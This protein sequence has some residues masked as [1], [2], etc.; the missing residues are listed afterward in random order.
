MSRQ[1]LM[2]L[3]DEYQALKIWVKLDGYDPDLNRELK[4][5]L[6]GPAIW[7]GEHKF[8]VFPAHW[9]TCVK[10]REVANRFDANIKISPSLNE[11]AMQEKG[12]QA[13]IPDVQSMQLV[14]LP[15]VRQ[16]YPGIWDAIT[17]RPYQ[18]VCAAFAA[19]NRSC[20]IADQPGLGK[21][22]QTIAAIVEA[23]ICGPIL[24]VAPKAAVQL[25][26]PQ[27][28]KRWLPTDNVITLDSKLSPSG[29]VEAVKAALATVEHGGK[30]C[31]LITSPNYVRI[32]AKVDE[33]GNY[34]KVNGE[35]VIHA[36]RETVLELFGVEWSAIVVD[37]SHQTL[38]GATGNKKKQSAQRLG[39]GALN[40]R[41]DGLRIAL[42][43]TPFRGKEY[44]LWG[45]LNWLRPD[46]Y[47]SYW[48]WI[49]RHFN[50]WHDGYGQQIGKMI[51]AE[52][53]YDE[54]RNV[55]IRRT[56]E[57]VASD[58]PAKLYGGWPLIPGGPV[59]VWLDMEPKQ[60]AA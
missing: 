2:G 18:T 20:S 53:M 52:A 38:A 12:R 30:R 25:T 58:L 28:L 55:M 46:N 19:R 26:W 13:T 6:P 41:K 27:E 10:A 24:V 56:K 16:H 50:T 33:Y 11:W 51:D 37:E 48:N 15:E 59:A 54:A 39:L 35:K 43:G 36:V 45:Q 40:V 44:Y 22:I 21:T 29:R 23:D 3:T 8:W 9:D 1:W 5:R 47:R 34:E 17:Q 32:R 14:D 49:K 31:W 4:A 60:A 42:S 7:N 57:E